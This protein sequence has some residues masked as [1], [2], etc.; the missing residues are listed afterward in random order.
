MKKVLI[1][2]LIIMVWNCSS[3]NSEEGGTFTVNG[4]IYLDGIPMADVDVDF[5]FARADQEKEILF[6]SQIIKTDSEGKFVFERSYIKGN[7]Q[8][9]IRAKNPATNEWTSFRQKAA[10]LGI[11]YKEDFHFSSSE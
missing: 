2:F 5:G 3:N 11:T 8:Y 10:L 1:L 9:R 7:H 6:D 4:T